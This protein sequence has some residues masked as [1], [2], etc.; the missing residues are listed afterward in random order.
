MTHRE[1]RFFIIVHAARECNERDVRLRGGASEY[2][3]RVEVCVGGVWVTVCDDMWDLSDATVVC[4]QLGYGDRCEIMTT[5]IIQIL[6]YSMLH[7]ASYPVRNY[8]GGGSRAVGSLSYQSMHLDNVSCNRSENRL[9]QCP[10]ATISAEDCP[11]N[12]EAGVICT[13]KWYTQIQQDLL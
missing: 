8:M 11:L 6:K 3:G 7:S 5:Y 9:D 4:R 2:D 1:I 10:Y 13:G 12:Y